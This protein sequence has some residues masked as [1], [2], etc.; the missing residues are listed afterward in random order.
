M[1]QFRRRIHE[2]DVPANQSRNDNEGMFERFERL[3]SI[4]EA[5]KALVEEAMRRAGQNQTIASAMLGI[6]PFAVNKRLNARE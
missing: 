5:C 2:N 1:D 6:T 4:K 3:P